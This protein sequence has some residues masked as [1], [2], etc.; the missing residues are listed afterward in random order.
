MKKLTITWFKAALIRAIRT[1]CQTAVSMIAVGAAISEV[2]WTTI[3]SVSAVAAIASILTSVAT[4]LP[5]AT[6][7]GV[8]VITDGDEKDIYTLNLDDDPSEWASKK[9][10]TLTVQHESDT[11]IDTEN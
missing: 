10:I 2:D 4:G 1:F 7:D 3:A 11:N 9:T 5:E 6:N 8:L